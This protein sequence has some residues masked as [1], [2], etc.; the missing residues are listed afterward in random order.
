MIFAPRALLAPTLLLTLAACQQASGPQ[1]RADAADRAA[2]RQRAEEVYNKQNRAE[3]YQTDT[4]VTDTRDA[5]F[6]TSGLT[7]P[8]AGLASRFALD[9]MV[10]D[11]LRSVS[12]NV[13]ASPGPA[14]AP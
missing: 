12:G 6:A 11:C 3:M 7:T 4:Y 10:S 2:C 5:P 8:N 1:A 13:G 14:L 9:T